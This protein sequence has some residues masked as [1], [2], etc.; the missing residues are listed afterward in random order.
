M[1]KEVRQLALL[2]GRTVRSQRVS[3]VP[4]LLSEPNELP[5]Q[6][7]VQIVTIRDP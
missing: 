1:R 6:T 7:P 2:S 4:L 3:A 5:F